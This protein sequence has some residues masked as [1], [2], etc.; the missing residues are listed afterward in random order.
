MFSII[1]TYNAKH[2]TVQLLKLRPTKP[3]TEIHSLADCCGGCCKACE[4]TE[5]FIYFFN[6]KFTIQT[7]IPLFIFYLGLDIDNAVDACNMADLFAT[8]LIIQLTYLG[9]NRRNLLT[10]VHYFKLDNISKTFCCRSARVDVLRDSLNQ[11]ASTRYWWCA[12]SVFFSNLWHFL[13]R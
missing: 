9:C 4:F 6:F 3:A 13:T 8:P 7:Y 11:E 5:L 12:A 10:V 2:S 1:C